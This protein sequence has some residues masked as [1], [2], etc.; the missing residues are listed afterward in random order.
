MKKHDNLTLII[1]KIKISNT[2]FINFIIV[3]LILLSP[4]LYI[5]YL[6]SS[7]L[8]DIK[9]I[10]QNLIQIDNDLVLIYSLEYDERGE[11]LKEI[12]SKLNNILN[13]SLV[14]RIYAF[15]LYEDISS[16]KS[17]LVNNEENIADKHKVSVSIKDALSLYKSTINYNNTFHLVL[18]YIIVTSLVVLVIMFLLKYHFLVE[19][20]NTVNN[21]GVISLD[22]MEKKLNLL[23]FDLHNDLTQKL[24]IISR[25]LQE[26]S[27]ND[28]NN[29]LSSQYAR[30]LLD[31]VRGYS[32]A[33]MTPEELY[34][35]F[36]GSIGKLCSD[37][38]IYSHLELNVKKMGLKALSISKEDSIHLY[39][40]LQE[41]LNNAHKH[42]LAQKIYLS[43][44]YSHPMLKLTIKD[45]GKGFDM[46][47]LTGK[48]IGMN[49][50]K[51]RLELLNA[52]YTF[53]SIKNKGTE[54]KFE[55]QIANEKCI[56]S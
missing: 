34:T 20:T 47:N 48:G 19:D 35:D 29:I 49:S 31:T 54:L 37:F 52:H 1:K 5:T 36:D 50:I 53:N 40:I 9:S 23:A 56:N 14:E 8:S 30:E 21:P 22:F 28:D 24:A 12:S 11:K 25:N 2:K 26:N 27:S 32:N 17:L 39:R 10:A 42:S 55:I 41:F 15:I 16:V 3:L 38:S 18:N 43:I 6:R 44:I 33:L 7:L 4:F 46:N 13:L 45:N 51:Y